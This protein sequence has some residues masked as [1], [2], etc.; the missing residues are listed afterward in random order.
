[1]AIGVL[2]FLCKYGRS[3]QSERGLEP[4]ANAGARA[5]GEHAL[6]LYGH[7]RSGR[8]GDEHPALHA[9]FGF[10]VGRLLCGYNH[11]VPY[12]NKCVV[13]THKREQEI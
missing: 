11:D 7:G 3:D 2:A 4:C 12:W 9:H 8:S 1:M 13:A 5:A 6:S 10:G